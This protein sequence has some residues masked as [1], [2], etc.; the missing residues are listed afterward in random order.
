MQ[1]DGLPAL[2]FNSQIA[3]N[4][5]ER[6]VL[7]IMAVPDMFATDFG[8]FHILVVDLSHDL[9]DQCSLTASKAATRSMGPAEKA[10]SY[11]SLI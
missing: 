2:I 6:F 1:M 3:A 9:G 7:T 4:D 5:A 10:G 8:D 11:S